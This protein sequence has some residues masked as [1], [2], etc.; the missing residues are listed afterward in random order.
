MLVVIQE[1]FEVVP[2]YN[3]VLV[4]LFHIL[5]QIFAILVSFDEN[6]ETVSFSDKICQD[7]IIV[8]VYIKYRRI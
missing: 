3:V 4:A 6:V 8:V 7:T 2:R 1:F 5:D